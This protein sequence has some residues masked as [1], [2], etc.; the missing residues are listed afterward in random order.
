[1]RWPGAALLLVAACGSRPNSGARHIT[2]G[3]GEQV[4]YITCEHRPNC[5]QLAGELCPEGYDTQEADVVARRSSTQS[6][7]SATR[8]GGVAWGSSSATTHESATLGMQIKC[9]GRDRPRE[10]ICGR[11]TELNPSQCPGKRRFGCT[12]Y[13]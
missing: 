2:N 6:R 13:D 3:D 5:L 9:R 12:Y 11:C 10:K 7:G 4:V 8:I 1:M